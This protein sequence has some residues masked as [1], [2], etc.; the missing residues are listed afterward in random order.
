MKNSFRLIAVAA[1]L[2][3][4]VG[5]FA[6]P[7]PTGTLNMSFNF[8][9]GSSGTFASVFHTPQVTFHNAKFSPTLDG[10]GDP[11]LGTDHWQI[12]TASDT[13]FPLLVENPS[14]YGRGAAPSP[15]NALNGLDQDILVQFDQAYNLSSFT[16]TLENSSFGVPFAAVNFIS[17]AST[18]LTVGLNQTVSGFV[19]TQGPV[20]GVTGVVLPGGKFYD[21]VSVTG[22]AAVPEPSTWA[23]LTGLV[24]LGAAALRRLQLAPST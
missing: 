11:I 2:A 1:F 7:P 18:V 14:L 17:G 9:S 23:V 10:F 21:N 3:A 15:G 19:F 16:F 13:A 5:A 24:A 20:V 22:A 8:D 12:D 4:A 6:T